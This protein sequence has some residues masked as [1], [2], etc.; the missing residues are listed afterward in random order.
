MEKNYDVIIVGGGLLG[1]ATAYQLANRFAGFLA[2]GLLAD[3]GAHE[4]CPDGTG[5]GN[6]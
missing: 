2:C 1:C 4:T 5:A 3:K 6:L